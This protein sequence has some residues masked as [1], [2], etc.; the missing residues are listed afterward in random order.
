[1]ASGV[2][3]LAAPEYECCSAQGR[4]RTAYVKRQ[5]R[6][7]SANLVSGQTVSIPLRRAS[8]HRISTPRRAIPSFKRIGWELERRESRDVLSDDQ[9]M[10]VV[11]AFIGFHRLQVRHVAEDGI[12]IGNSIRAQNVAPHARTLQRHP[13]IV[14]L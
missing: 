3:R 8:C 13:D 4:G 14:A 6:N 12:L 1:M 7:A 5:N 11:R 10:N 2:P 9:R